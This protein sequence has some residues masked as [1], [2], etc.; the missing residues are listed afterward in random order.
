LLPVRVGKLAAKMS[1]IWLKDFKR[2]TTSQNG[3]DG[4]LAAIFHE[5]GASNKWC[6]EFGAWDAIQF[7]NTHSLL[8]SGWSG[9]LIESDSDRFE[10]LKINTQGL[11]V[12]P[13]QALVQGNIDSLLSGTPIPTDFD[14]LS[15]DIDG[16]DY[17]VWEALKNYRPRVVV[18]EVNS[19]FPPGVQVLPKWGNSPKGSSIESTVALAKQKGYELAL[20][21]GNAIFVLREYSE[22]LNID[23]EHW[24]ELFDRS[25]VLGEF[26]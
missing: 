17:L 24:Q 4:V 5:I 22:R 20:H 3:E 11:N 26:L 12:V 21:T 23:T 8:V 15:I 9:V 6:C 16:E 25:Q 2:N 1:S 14:L 13:I 19:G 7:S 18:I 10:Q